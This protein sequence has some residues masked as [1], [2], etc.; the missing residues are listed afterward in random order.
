[1]NVIEKIGCLFLLTVCS[2]QNSTGQKW[3]WAKEATSSQNFG[4]EVATVV[5]DKQSNAYIT[6]LFGGVLH[7]GSHTLS[8]ANTFNG[9]LVKYD[10]NGNVLWAKQT[11]T[12]PTTT[13]NCEPW[14]IA[15]DR[16]GYLYIT[17]EFADTATIGTYILKTSSAFPTE[18]VFLAKYD[19]NGNV[20]W[21]KQA[22]I[23]PTL[24]CNGYG[25]SVCTDSYGNIYVAGSFQD[26]MTFG[27]FR[28]M[29][30]YLQGSFF[31]VKYDSSGNVIWAK[32]A[33]PNGNSSSIG[34]YVTVDKSNH[35]YVTGQ[36]EG[37]LIIGA[38]TLSG[39][40][41][42]FIIKYD[43][44]GNVLWTQQSH[45]YGTGSALGVSLATD[46][47]K[48]VYVTGSF[49]SNIILG[50]DT[51]LSAVNYPQTDM[52]LAKYDSTGKYIWSV[53][54]KILDSNSWT[55]F[56][57]ATDTL[58][59]VYV[60][61]GGWNNGWNQGNPH[62][63]IKLGN[64]IFKTYNYSWDG[65]SVIVKF[66]S[67]GEELC[68]S[69]VPGGGDDQN[70]IA[71]S[72]SGRYI[73]FAGDIYDTATLGPDKLTVQ[74]NESAFIARWQSCCT[75]YLGLG[76][77]TI[78]EHSSI[79]LNAPGGPVYQWSNGATSSSITVSPNSSTYYQ[80]TIS[81][82]SCVSDSTIYVKVKPSPIPKITADN[83]ICLGKPD[84]IKASGGSLYNWSNGSTSS[85]IIVNP[86]TSTQ[87]TVAISNGL[88]TVKDS[89]TVQVFPYPVAS[90]SNTQIIC[91]GQSAALTASGGTIYSWNNGETTSSITV[92]PA[93][94]TTYTVNISNGECSV[95]DSIEVLVKP[96][97]AVS[98]CCDS[99]ISIGENVQLISSGGQS[100]LW[101]PPIGL[102][103][104]TCPDPTAMPLVTTTY[105]LTITNDS[106]CTAQR[107]VTIDV[108]CGDVFVP[109]VFSP[110]GAHNNILYVR[111]TCIASMD[112][113]VFD[114][115]G[116]KIFESHDLNTGWNGTYKG[117]PMN[118]GTYIWYLKATLQDG[119]SIEKKGNVTLVR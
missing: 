39:N 15:I 49:G 69:I 21:A 46:P 52:F 109:D 55:G 84:T 2:I 6:G 89:T 94:N 91:H 13:S 106:G 36:Y 66:N 119:T 4:T 37:P 14:P 1:M 24:D 74:S 113:L 70:G 12:P 85:S 45:Y 96:A 25:N 87:Y 62:Y 16:K 95:I 79:Q 64:D 116:N 61:M 18:D 82:G 93:N 100:Y 63:S 90:V 111:S 73:Y 108:S 115:W 31:L 11:Q 51:L 34:M 65:T 40:Q 42:S 10:S 76:D 22:N 88:C 86:V 41:N 107:F 20:I 110:N 67:S 53:A 50:S 81:N 60:T 83:K 26:T 27:S 103:C 102:S 99:V 29:S 78:C 7:F 23:P 28:L 57:L 44:G 54:G 104:D 48:N 33:P 30:T 59:N 19:G 8:S 56:V 9:F 92:D 117:Q 3:L 47:Q 114:R 112:F 17:G 38:D 97:P 75:Y 68:G 105:T 77:T 32:Q 118:T 43:T 35:I 98:I 58:N 80:V 5:M 71:V 72:P 101:S